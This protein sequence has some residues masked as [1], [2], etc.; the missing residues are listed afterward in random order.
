M[1]KCSNKDIDDSDNDDE[2]F[3]DAKIEESEDLGDRPPSRAVGKKVTY[4]DEVVGT[5]EEERRK[6]SLKGG[7]ELASSLE[8][9]S[10]F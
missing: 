2:E 10:F 7:K 1:S 9:I 4:S 8:Q 5:N 6:S 3:E